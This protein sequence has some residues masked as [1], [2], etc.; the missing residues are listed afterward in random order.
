MTTKQKIIQRLNEE[1]EQRQ[2]LLR[3][4]TE[5]DLGDL[6]VEPCIMS[7]SRIDFD[8]LSHDKVINVIKAVGGKWDKTPASEGGRINYSTTK[9]GIYFQCWSGK[10]PPNCKIVEV[11]ETIPAQPERVVTRRKL[12]CQ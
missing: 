2:T 1:I 3:E 6:D 4:I 7:G 5:I 9:N 10:P 12:V 11:F 8:N